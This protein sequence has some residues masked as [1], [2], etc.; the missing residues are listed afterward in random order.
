MY[1]LYYAQSLKI[2]GG[3]AVP[4]NPSGSA[5]AMP[6]VGL[7]S[8]IVTFPRHTHLRF[9]EQLSTEKFILAQ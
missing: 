8:V 3:E 1:L 6:W 2:G 7:L 4:A 5:T 9:G